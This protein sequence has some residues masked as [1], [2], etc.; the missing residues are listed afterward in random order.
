MVKKLIAILKQNRLQV[1][2]HKFGWYV[3]HVSTVQLLLCV[4]KQLNQYW[5]LEML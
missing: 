4:N 3:E 5:P 2:F 1:Y